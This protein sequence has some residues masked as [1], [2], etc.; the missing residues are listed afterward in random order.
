MSCSTKHK[1]VNAVLFQAGWF[2]CIL[3]PAYMALFS[4][5]III[6]IHLKISEDSSKEMFLI[7]GAGTMGYL[8]DSIFSLT[9]RINLEPANESMIYLVCVWLLFISTLNSSMKWF[10]E[11]PVK[12]ALLG[13]LAPFSYFA[14]QALGKVKYSEPLV[15]SMIMHALLWSVF[16]LI[17]HKLYFVQNS[18]R[19]NERQS[20][21]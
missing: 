4:T 3:L 7:F 8:M 21:I 14:A 12:A 20:T 5:V 17:I 10:C 15:T 18:Q 16:M 13:A 1:I 6:A 9:G 11:T 2:S 19:A